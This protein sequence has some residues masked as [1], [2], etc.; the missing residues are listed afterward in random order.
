MPLSVRPVALFL[1]TPLSS[2]KMGRRSGNPTDARL[3]QIR[4][5]GGH[6]DDR[7]ARLVP[8]AAPRFAPAKATAPGEARAS[9]TPARSTH[10]NQPVVD[11]TRAIRAP[12]DP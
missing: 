12:L 3:I 7:Y 1:T 2:L 8:P 6:S 5:T 11:S 9:A 4:H 10:L